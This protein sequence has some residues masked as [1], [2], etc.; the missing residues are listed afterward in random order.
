[1]IAYVIQRA[2]QAVAVM[3]VVSL[4]SFMLF[5]FVGDPVDNMVGQEA[6]YEERVAMRDN[7]GLNDPFLIQFGR[8]MGNAMQG[9]F[10]I[11]YRIQRPVADLIAE[12]MP[13]TL[14]LV[15]ISAILSVFL[16]IPM[17]IYTGI[18]PN[19]W[20]SR[21]FLVGSLVGVTLP[22]FVIGI[23]LI[24][25]FAVGLGILPSFG[26]GEA[27]QIGWWS[28]GLLTASGWKA[29]IMPS[30]TLA[31]FQ[32][33][34]IMRLVRSEMLEVMR[35]DYIKF[36]RARGLPD[37]TINFGHAFKNTLV[38]VI[39]IVGLNLGSL[40]A[41]SIITETVFQWPGM[42]FLFIQAVG[43]ADIPVMAAY[44]VLVAV[45]FVAINFFVDILYFVVDPRLRVDKTVA[46]GN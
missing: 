31:L 22:T 28:T 23:L 4:V 12:R 34:I 6:S 40:I 30:V 39:T 32:M 26:R 42:G 37:R 3:V 15:I 8:F 41:F 13:A 27:I 18:K 36:A 9:E 5:N 2:L 11:S 10:G 44:L 38:P 24:Y 43:F 17:G 1:M 14:E 45:I 20:L 7:L 25:I 33:T 19:S 35:T 16:G 29:I 46:A 21:S